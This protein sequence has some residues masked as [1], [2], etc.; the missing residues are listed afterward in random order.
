MKF[1][2]CNSPLLISKLLE[3]AE[4][5]EV[6]SSDEKRK[7]YDKKCQ[8]SC[9]QTAAGSWPTMKVKKNFEDLGLD[10]KTFEEFQRNVNTRLVL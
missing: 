5:Y 8:E 1:A 6:L 4:A 9:M 3:V 7:A 10:Y 2:A